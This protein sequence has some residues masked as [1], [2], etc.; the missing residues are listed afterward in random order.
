MR[1]TGRTIN[2]VDLMLEV[3]ASRSQRFGP[4][5]TFLR[6]AGLAETE[7]ESEASTLSSNPKVPLGS[8]RE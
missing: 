6:T 7:I 2:Q 1:T 4:H 5:W 3:K 8:P